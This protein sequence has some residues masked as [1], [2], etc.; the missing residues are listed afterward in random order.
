[1]IDE[2]RP[3][4]GP[5]YRS[6]GHQ[7]IAIMGYSHHGEPASDSADKTIDVLSDVI[8]GNHPPTQFFHQ[9]AEYFGNDGDRFWEKV[10]FFNFAP[11]A[12]GDSDQKHRDLDEQELRE[13]RDRFLALLEVLQPDLLFVFTRKGWN[14]LP[15]SEEDQRGTSG[16][17]IIA[18][19]QFDRHHYRL[20]NGKVVQ[21]FGL[22][23]PERATKSVMIAAVTAALQMEADP[24]T[25]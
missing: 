8:A 22:R 23:H 7:R 4:E 16:R 25:A 2:H 11:R 18:G 10:A 15:K 19:E 3:H 12:I 6:D 1:M 24:P 20:E 5:G 13:A 17:E 14:N 21:A 9:I